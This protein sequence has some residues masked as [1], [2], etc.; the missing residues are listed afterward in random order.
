MDL[1]GAAH[2][3]SS[4]AAGIELFTIVLP[5][6]PVADAGQP[7]AQRGSVRETQC[8]I[9]GILV[10]NVMSKIFDRVHVL[11]QFYQ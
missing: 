4:R 5:G 8:C 2:W 6:A 1:C 3:L 7:F 10:H 9:W 11:F